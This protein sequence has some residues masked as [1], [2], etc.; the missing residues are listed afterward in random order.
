VELYLHSSVLFLDV[1]LLIAEEA[2]ETD[3][4][5]RTAAVFLPLV[6]SLNFISEH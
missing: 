2:T 4:P 5:K 6:V 3:R 1:V